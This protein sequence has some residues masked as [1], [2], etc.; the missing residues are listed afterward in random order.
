MDFAAY[1]F[2]FIFCGAVF[3]LCLVSEVSCVSDAAND[4]NIK[5]YTHMVHARVNKIQRNDYMTFVYETPE[6]AE[7]FKDYIEVDKS[8][9]ISRD[10]A[11]VPLWDRRIHIFLCFCTLFM[12]LWLWLEY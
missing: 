7:F 5:C 1:Q 2:I 8:E 10:L 4:P 6:R 9:C 3:Y 11:Y 12:S